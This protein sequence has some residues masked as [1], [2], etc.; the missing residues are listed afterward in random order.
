MLQLI[1][2]EFTYD[3]LVEMD[4]A[5]LGPGRVSWTAGL[6]KQLGIICATG[7]LNTV[8]VPSVV[9]S[10]FCLCQLRKISL[11]EVA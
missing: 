6:C 5:G 9:T 1:A 8:Y 11:S 10:A 2:L 4:F 3:E 7:N